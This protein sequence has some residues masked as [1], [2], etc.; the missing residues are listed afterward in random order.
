MGAASLNK[1]R[2]KQAREG[3]AT[4][5]KLKLQGKYKRKSRENEAR[6]MGT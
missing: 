3:K 2:T 1:R 4:W 6:Q 5:E